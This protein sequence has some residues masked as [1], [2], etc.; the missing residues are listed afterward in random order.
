VSYGRTPFY[1][2]ECAC[3][4]V[5]D[6]TKDP[7]HP[8]AR[9]VVFLAHVV[10]WDELCQFITKAWERGDAP[11]ILNRGFE[12]I[13]NPERADDWVTDPGLGR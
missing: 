1:I 9:H 2:Y 13:G 3:G 11:A 10:L 7:P 4:G 6:E 12:I 5:P 8:K